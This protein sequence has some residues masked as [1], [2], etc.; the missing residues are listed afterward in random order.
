LELTLPGPDG[1][2]YEN[3]YVM[4]EIAERQRIVFSHPHFHA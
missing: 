3:D 2:D 1:A 4:E